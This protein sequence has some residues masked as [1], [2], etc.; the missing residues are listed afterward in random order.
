MENVEIDVVGVRTTTDFEMIEIVGDKDPYYSLLWIYWAYEN[1]DIIDLKRGTM[2]FEADDIK[3]VQLL[4]PYLGPRYVEL[5]DHNMESKALDQLYTI[6]I[7]T[8][9]G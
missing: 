3:V 5:V 8:R 6:T 9:I 7:A 1:Y 2:T 4:D